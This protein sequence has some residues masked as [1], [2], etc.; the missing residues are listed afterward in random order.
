V[1]GRLRTQAK[2]AQGRAMRLPCTLCEEGGDVVMLHLRD[3]SRELGPGGHVWASKCASVC[4]LDHDLRKVYAQ[5]GTYGLGQP[6]LFSF[7]LF[8]F[9]F[10]PC[11]CF[12]IE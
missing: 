10:P 11:C 12:P 1:E 9:F 8:C 4:L 2:A 7:A 5:D 6:L 3:S